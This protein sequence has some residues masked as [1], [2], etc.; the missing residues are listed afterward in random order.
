MIPKL[1]EKYLVFDPF[2]AGG[3]YEKGPDEPFFLDKQH[4]TSSSKSGT[5]P[6]TFPEHIVDSD[7]TRTFGWR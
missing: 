7:K 2:V 6:K 1:Q 3:L 4:S 5:Q